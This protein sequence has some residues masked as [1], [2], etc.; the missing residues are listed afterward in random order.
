M[1]AMTI[2]PT[3]TTFME[4]GAP[5]APFARLTMRPPDHVAVNFKGVVFNRREPGDM[6]C[7]PAGLVP[8]GRCEDGMAVGRGRKVMFPPIPIFQE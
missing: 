3:E 2:P 4:K 7:K 5:V 6:G 8:W 1:N